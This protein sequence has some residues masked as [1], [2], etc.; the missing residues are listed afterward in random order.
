MS[1]LLNERQ[2]TTYTNQCKTED[3]GINMCEAFALMREEASLQGEARGRSELI[4]SLI[5]KQYAKGIP[6]P[7]IADL[8]DCEESYVE[9][10]LRSM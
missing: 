2:F 8:L 1:V 4:S 3:G 9:M 5:C 10:V 7:Q 6:V